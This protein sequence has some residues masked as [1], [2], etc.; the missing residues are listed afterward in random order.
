MSHIKRLNF[1]PLPGLSS[2][3]LQTILHVYC[4][5]SPSPPSQN[6]LVKLDSKNTL[7]C[8]I[9]TPLNWQDDGKTVALVHGLGGSHA[10][11]YMVRLA[12]KFYSQGKKVVR[13]N[14]RGCGS[15]KG[16]A[17]LPYNAGTSS[18]VLHVLAALREQSPSSEIILI[19]F[20]LGGSIVLK[21]A[22]ELGEKAKG[23]VKTFI[24]VCA[25]LDLAQTLRLIERKRHTFYHKY[26][27]KS[28]C[29]QI[30]A[31]IDQKVKTIYE[32]DDLITAP[33]WGYRGADDYYQQ[34]SSIQ[35]LPKIKHETHILFAED[36]PF[37]SMRMLK[38]L[39]IPDQVHIWASKHGGHMGF[40]G[41]TPNQKSMYW[42][43]H[44]LVNWAEG[45]FTS[46]HLVSN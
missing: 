20:S 14:M 46:N 44:L 26:F 24:S 25:P 8:V 11:N 3:H 23:T 39:S 9:S 1:K 22:G 6:M 28:I 34:C 27:L 10:S 31:W 40:L 37:I 16:L 30:P 15:G 29:K 35:F 17:H 32:F 18:D 21:L 42:M 41:P 43:D 38:G 36:D 4:P 7:S 12:D 45:D 19:G 13:I 2:K 5:G 33:L